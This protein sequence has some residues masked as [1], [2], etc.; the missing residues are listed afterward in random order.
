MSNSDPVDVHRAL[1]KAARELAHATDHGS[2]P[3]YRAAIDNLEEKLRAVRSLIE[4]SVSSVVVCEFCGHPAAEHGR[5]LG[6]GH[7]IVRTERREVRSYVCACV[8]PTGDESIGDY[9]GRPVYVSDAL[10]EKRNT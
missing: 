1:Q 8:I 4:W 10:P 5:R 6:C 9:C 7:T 2:Y 3:E